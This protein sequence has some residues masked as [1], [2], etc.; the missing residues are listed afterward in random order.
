MT[1]RRI[2]LFFIFIFTTFAAFSQRN[3]VPNPSFEA[4]SSAPIIQKYNW[5]HYASWQK[6]SLTDRNKYTLTKGWSQPTGGTPDYLNSFRSSLFGFQTQT[7]RTGRGRF[8]L[9]CGIGKNSFNAWLLQD[10]NYS[11]YLETVLVK[12]L[13]AGKIYC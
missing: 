7:A 6:D 4:D 12:P 9:I 2:L 5:R 13:E 1:F 11:E 3:L 8:G 10:G